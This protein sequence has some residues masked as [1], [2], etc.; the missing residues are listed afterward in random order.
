MDTGQMKDKVYKSFQSEFGEVKSAEDF[1]N[2]NLTIDGNLAFVRFYQRHWYCRLTS[3]G[4]KKN[5]WRMDR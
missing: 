1:A 5:S 2:F 4:V 3:R